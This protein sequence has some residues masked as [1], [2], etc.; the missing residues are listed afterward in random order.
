MRPGCTAG[1]P[2][3]F[4]KS[5]FRATLLATAAVL[6]TA[7]IAP[8]QTVSTI[9]DFTGAANSGANPWYVTLVQG[10]NGNLYGTTYNGGKDLYGTV[11]N[12]TTTGSLKNIY[13]F[14]GTTTDGANPTG[15]LT[16]GTDGNFY[17]TTQQGGVHSMGTAFKIT[18]SGTIT[19]LHSFNSFVDGAFP[20]GP[21]ILASDGN[22]YGTTSGGG[23]NGH[24]IVYK[25]TT[26]GTITKI[27]QFDVTHGFS[28]IA[29]PTQG[30]DGFLYIPVS[31]G[32]TSYCGTIL[33]M[34]T[35]GVINNT[36]DFPC[37]AGGS[38]P[39]GPLVQ[40]SNGN[41]Y[42][43]TQD[44]GTNGEG[45]IYQVTTGLAVTVLHS[46][47]TTFGDGTFPSAGLL[48]ATDGNYYGATSDGGADGDGTLVNTSTSGTYTSLYSFDNTAN[49]TQM[50]PLSPPI[51]STDGLLYGMTEFGGPGN[52]GTIYSLDMG[53]A[54]FVNTALFS[55]KEGATITILGTH[56]K[57]TKEVSFN[58]SVA[59]FKVLSDTHLSATVPA[60]ATTG[61]IQVIT[62]GGALLSR[63]N[64]VVKP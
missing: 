5:I 60:G 57:G 64:F 43:T 32:G 3:T 30:A 41:F 40:A 9:Y 45:T 59:K 2:R 33:K 42:S 52:D 22:F 15:G 55:G 44:G 10:T 19:I 6:C 39:I 47:G 56:L 51:Q 37:G 17:G 11:F 48:L 23:I 62:P 29:P 7:A 21:P 25:M 28:P 24:G 46:F 31:E 12:V 38:F 58:G 54:P 34:S 50:S 53:L 49:L 16:L 13:S 20:W 35:A 18:Q 14:T 61:P 36:Y 27:Y 4:L 8:A 63:K 26:A 1:F